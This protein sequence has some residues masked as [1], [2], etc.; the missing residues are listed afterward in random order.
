MTCLTPIFT[1]HKHMF[2]RE[3][4]KVRSAPD[5]FDYL[6]RP[7]VGYLKALFYFFQMVLRRVITSALPER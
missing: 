5:E 1:L 6:E 2:T 4:K 3:R 7:P